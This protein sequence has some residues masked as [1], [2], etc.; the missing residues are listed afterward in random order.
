MTSVSDPFDLL[1]PS[2]VDKI[3]ANAINPYAANLN[4]LA[5]D[6]ALSSIWTIYV[7]NSI[8]QIGA[9]AFAGNEC[10]N[11]L[12]FEPGIELEYIGNDIVLSCV[13]L[14]NFTIA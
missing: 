3:S 8:T 11:D 9:S 7:P 10:L 4:G 1:I 13:E 5:H 14:D 12:I 6:R 2:F